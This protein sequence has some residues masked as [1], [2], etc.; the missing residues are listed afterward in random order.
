MIFDRK[1]YRE[2]VIKSMHNAGYW[3]KEIQIDNERKLEAEVNY[4]LKNT[5][6]WKDFLKFESSEYKM[7]KMLIIYLFRSISLQ[8]SG[9]CPGFTK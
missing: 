8:P 3:N 6:H 2:N 7:S 1:K 4:Q 9:A 5:E